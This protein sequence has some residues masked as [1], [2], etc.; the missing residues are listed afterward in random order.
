MATS[1]AT[2]FYNFGRSRM[3]RPTTG[4]NS[5]FQ[6]A[7]RDA[8]YEIHD[9]A[10]RNLLVLSL[11]NSWETNT[12]GTGIK[13]RFPNDS[14]NQLW[15]LSQAEIDADGMQSFYGLQSLVARSVLQS[16]EVF[17]HFRLRRPSDGLQVPLQI[18]LLESVML[19]SHRAG[20]NDSDTQNAI[21][22]GI[23]YDAIGRRVA[24]HF[25][26][27]HPGEQT[28]R[29]TFPEQG[30][31]RVPAAEI[32]H[33]GVPSVP[34]E[35]RFISPLAVAIENLK[36]Y[37]EARLNMAERLRIASLF[38]GFVQ[39]GFEDIDAGAT[40]PAPEDTLLGED[41][42]DSE[43]N[44]ISNQFERPDMIYL[45]DG[46]TITF[47][48]PPDVGSSFLPFMQQFEQLF[49][50]AYGMTYEQ[51]SGNLHQVS[52][53]SARVG[54]LEMRRRILQFVARCLVFQFSSRFTRRWLQEAVIS[55]AVDLPGFAEDPTPWYGIEWRH[56]G[57]EAINP[58]DEIMSDE[59]AVQAGFDSRSNIA[60][61]KR[62]RDPDQLLREIAR[63]NQEAEQLSLNFTTMVQPGSQ[64]AAASPVVGEAEREQTAGAI[65]LAMGK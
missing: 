43:G 12:V 7:A 16:G 50:A 31:V 58:I 35:K 17:A 44:A 48:Q 23:E 10:R 45:E 9:L 6:S 36:I 5:I 59:K 41:P 49:A 39:R 3:R 33:I 29:P 19:P 32:L 60:L 51:I 4:P 40:S 63:D 21:E 46:Q 37:D 30:T 62:G 24:Y 27:S 15:D 2:S 47:P 13:P 28:T 56:P 34:G 42:P 57:W 1:P 8:Q 64:A 20:G 18:Q 55:N 25:Y 14:L 26:R 54:Q 11:L 61:T 38:P 52:F 53:S 65:A 22:N